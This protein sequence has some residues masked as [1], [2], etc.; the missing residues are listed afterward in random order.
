MV[1]TA[2]DLARFNR[3]GGDNFI[4][5]HA[6]CGCD[7]IGGWITSDQFAKGSMSW[8]TAM[9][10]SG[11]AVSPGAGV[12]GEG[13]TRS[14]IVASLMG[15]LNIR[16]GYWA[17]NPM[18]KNR[19]A[20]N[21]SQDYMPTLIYPGIHQGL[22]NMG[23]GKHA[24]YL[25]LTDGGHFDNTGIY[26]LIRR[27]AEV[28]FLADGGADPDYEFDDLSNAI[29]RVRVDFGVSIEFHPD[30]GLDCVT[31]NS[32]GVDA[33]AT[34]LSMARRGFAVAHVQYQSKSGI[35]IVLKPTL[36]RDLPQDIYRYRREHPTFPSQTTANQFFGE[37]QLE[38]YRELGYQLT[39]R[40]LR[41]A[42]MTDWFRL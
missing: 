34:K 17:A 4:M 40:C 31:P 7:A 36:V 3:R 25:Q 32:D 20:Q 33:F 38:A 11:A 12:A 27:E 15:L 18:V 8:A 30:Y 21:W 42:N 41:E 29:E 1:I 37:R 35:L 19:C 26:E 28:I 13:V 9:S 23:L 16:L 24:G 14:R 2:E 39:K 6:Y 5:S 22:F 10:I